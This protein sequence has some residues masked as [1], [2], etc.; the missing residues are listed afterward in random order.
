MFIKYFSMIIL[1]KF[2]QKPKM[3]NKAIL[4]SFIALLAIAFV[5]TTVMASDMVTITEVRVNGI[6]AH[7]N[8][9]QPL[10]N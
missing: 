8:L 3:K 5:L 6:V 2:T 4:V 7:N 10:Y 1:T 9:D